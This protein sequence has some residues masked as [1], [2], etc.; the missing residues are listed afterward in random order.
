ME[1]IKYKNFVIK[2]N[3]FGR[4]DLFKT[5]TRTKKQT[6]EKEAANEPKEL[7]NLET[8]INKR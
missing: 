5:V 7:T 4:Y 2:P 3:R 6:A 1:A 8:L